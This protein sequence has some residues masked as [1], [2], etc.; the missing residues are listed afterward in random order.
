MRVP[1]PADYGVLALLGSIM[2]HDISLPS[3]SAVELHCCSHTFLVNFQLKML[4]VAAISWG[5]ITAA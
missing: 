5:K 4:L 1:L 2:K 3:R